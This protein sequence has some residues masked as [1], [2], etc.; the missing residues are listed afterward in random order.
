MKTSKLSKK[1]AARFFE[2]EYNDVSLQVRNHLA[3][4]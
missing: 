4:L 1:E 3:I 2:S